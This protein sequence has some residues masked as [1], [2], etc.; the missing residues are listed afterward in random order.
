M[1]AE[2]KIMTSVSTVISFIKEKLRSDIVE[3][4]NRNMIKIDK[5]EIQKTCNIIDASIEASFSKS[6]DEI[7]RVAKNLKV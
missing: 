3:A 6:A 2:T 5:N 7:I 1:S 4:V